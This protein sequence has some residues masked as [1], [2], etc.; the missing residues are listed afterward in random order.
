MPAQPHNERYQALGNGDL[1]P[2]QLDGMDLWDR[3]VML[4]ERHRAI[5][6]ILVRRAVT[7][8]RRRRAEEQARNELAAGAPPPAVPT[9]LTTEE[10]R[11]YAEDKHWPLREMAR[12]LLGRRAGE[13]VSG[14]T[15]VGPANLANKELRGYAEDKHWPLRAMAR[16]LLWRR[17]GNTPVGSQPG[18]RRY[19]I[20][21]RNTL[22]SAR[23]NRAERFT[24]G[25][26]VAETALRLAGLVLE[27][28]GE[29][30]AVIPPNT[31]VPSHG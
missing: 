12:E 9:D 6:S 7:E 21:L 5:G 1:T 24:I 16:E 29:T 22:A 27:R 10:L 3:D 26:E 11:G 13:Q 20:A 17:A 30:A 2:Q 28:E 14:N 25:T 31:E 8:I 15:P 4:D 18:D 19:M 23:A